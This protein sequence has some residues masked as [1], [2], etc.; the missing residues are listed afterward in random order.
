VPAP[1]LTLHNATVHYGA[2]RALDSVSL[3]VDAGDWIAVSGDNGSGKTTLLSV[4]A[5]VI[6]PTE[7][8]VERAPGTRVALLLQEPDNQ[9]VASS[10]RHELALSMPHALDDS[11]RRARTEDAVRRFALAGLLDRNPHA[12]SGGEKQ[13]LALA[14]VWLESPTVL[15]LDEPLAY[16]DA[17]TRDRVVA[18]VEELNRNGTAIVWTTPGDEVPHARARVSLL[19]GRAQGDTARA[20]VT[21]RAVARR[22]PEVPPRDTATLVAATDAA[23]GYRDLPVLTG[24]TLAIARGECVGVVGRN[25]AGKS[26]LLLCLGGALDPSGGTVVRDKTVRVAYLPQ[27][28]ERLFFSETVEEEVMFGLERQGLGREEA[29]ARAHA[30]LN[31]VGLDSNALADCSP[32]HLSAG[33]MRRVALAVAVALAPDLLLLDEPASG[34]DRAGL[35]VLERVI[36]RACASGSAV[37]LASH[38]EGLLAACNRVL[39]VADGRVMAVP[40]AFLP[41]D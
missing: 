5:G 26:T 8:R 6:A 34:M 23:M 1:L 13:R 12:L 30:A 32:F 33:E 29:R 20:P 4:L 24:V 27:N 19:D 31:D 2:R 7:G 28:P 17:E 18:F 41:G 10:V 15:L 38:D 35:S 39:T 3:R 40:A 22:R 16:L 21:A 11:V 9:F 25:G 37:V 36:E 14:T